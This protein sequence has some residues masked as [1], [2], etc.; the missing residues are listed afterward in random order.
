VLLGAAGA[1]LGLVAV[2]VL[3]PFRR[4]RK[5]PAPAPASPPDRAPPR[6][7]SVELAIRRD[8]D[9]SRITSYSLVAAGQEQLIGSVAPL[10]PSDDLRLYLEFSRPTYWYLVQI[11]PAGETAIVG[12]TA[13]PEIR[14]RVPQTR[15]QMARFRAEDP[16]G[17]HLLLL[18]TSDVPPVAGEDVLAGKLRGLAAVAH[19][20]PPRWSQLRAGMTE[21]QSAAQLPQDLLHDMESALPAGFWPAHALFLRTV[22]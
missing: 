7:V 18:V 22:P 3:D 15:G 2:L 6:V 17:V 5:P 21:Q 19:K 8:Q 16:K 1:A 14:G 13:R 4:F 20:L 9:D 10:G 12:Q 11:D